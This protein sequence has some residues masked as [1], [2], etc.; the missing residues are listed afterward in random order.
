M[1][2]ARQWRTHPAHWPLLARLSLALLV[3][4]LCAGSGLLLAVSELEDQRQAAR[5]RQQDLRVQ[6]QAAL[7]QRSQQPALQSRETALAMQLAAQQAQLWPTEQSQPDLLQAK[8]ARRASECGLILESFKPGSG[9]LTAAIV[10]RGSHAGLMRFVELV[11]SLPLPVLF[12]RLD[13]SVAEAGGQA[14][15]QM[16]ATVSAPVAA[17]LAAGEKKEFVP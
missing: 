10:L 16:N 2:P 14:V 9:K 8:L 4:L 3:T 11:S 17:S 12:E 7:T 13:I 5:Q 15:L 1:S 6:Y